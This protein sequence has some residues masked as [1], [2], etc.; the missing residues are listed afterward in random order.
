MSRT[1]QVL[2]RTDHPGGVIDGLRTDGRRRR[3]EVSTVGRDDNLV[4][5]GADP[6][7]SPAFTGLPVPPAGTPEGS[8]QLR[9]LFMACRA[10]FRAQDRVRLVGLKQYA[11]IFGTVAPE[12]GPPYT[13]RR[14]ITS[15]LWR[16]FDGNISWHVQRIPPI[17]RDQRNPANADSLMYQ[18]ALAPALL[19]QSLAGGAYVPPNAGRP[20]GKPLPGCDLGNLHDIRYPWVDS[21]SE[22][23][24]SI[25]IE[26]PCDVVCYIS[27]A[28]HGVANVGPTPSTAQIAA[29]TPEDQ[30]WLAFKTTCQYGRVAASMIFEEER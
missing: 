16:F 9:Y 11:D 25:P 26:T 20:W 22:R 7:G 5:V 4:L 10:R 27:V 2:Q 14:Q 21:Q 24:L 19:Y 1:G 12:G 17:W 6:W 8:P 28:Q 30:F 13:F 18:D 29:M 15:P 23:E 3:F